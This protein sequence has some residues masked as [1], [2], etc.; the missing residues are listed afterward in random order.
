MREN[1]TDTKEI[2]IKKNC[3]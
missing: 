2:G 1:D 3:W